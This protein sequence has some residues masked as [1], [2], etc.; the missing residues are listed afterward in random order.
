[1]AMICR[2]EAMSDAVFT[3]FVLQMF[4]NRAETTPLKNKTTIVKPLS[5]N[6]L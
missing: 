1:M 2:F 3:P 5:V 4:C 6:T